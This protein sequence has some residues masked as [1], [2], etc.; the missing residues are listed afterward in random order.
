MSSMNPGKEFTAGAK[1]F[2]AAITIAGASHMID[3]IFYGR[4]I[5]DLASGIGFALLAFG[6]Y[7][8][9][10]RGEPVPSDR[11]RNPVAYSGSVLGLL[12]VIAAIVMKHWP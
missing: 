9:S 7:A 6:L 8:N 3:F 5:S 12:L 4:H 2:S 11:S 10:V 1:L